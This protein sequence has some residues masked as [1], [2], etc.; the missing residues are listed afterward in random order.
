[1]KKY[2]LKTFWCSMN[3]ADSEKINMVL[4]QL[5]IKLSKKEIDADIIIFNTCSV[6]NKWEDRVLWYI[7]NIIK[8]NYKK[9]TSLKKVIWVTWCM[10]KK[11][12]LNKSY[13][14][15]ESKRKTAKKIEYIDSKD[16]IFNNDDK[17]FPK[18]KLL[19]FTFRIEELKY[20]PFILSNIYSDL[21]IN[22]YQID[23]YLKLKQL[24]DNPVSA[25]IIIQTWCDNYCSFCIVPYTRWREISRN[26]EEIVDEAK[27]AINLWAKEIILIGQN[28]N[29]YWKNKNQLNWDKI[30]NKWIDNS[31]WSLFRV[32]LNKLN[33][34]KWLDRIRFTSSNPHD[35]TD[36]ILRSH[37][38]LEKIC[39]YLHFALQ[40][41][42]ND[43]LKKM[44]RKHTYEDFK[45]QVEYLRG[46]DPLFSISTD[47]IVWFPWET[48]EMFNETIKAFEELQF[49]FAYIAR[50]SERKWT[51]ASKY[52]MDNVGDNIKSE[53]WHIL[54]NLLLKII[55]NRNKLMLWREELIL[56]QWNKDWY[57][58]WRTRNFKEVFFKWNNSIQIW[59]YVKVKI[60]EVNRY[61]LKG[62]L[63][64][65]TPL[66]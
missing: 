65:L 55:Q 4:N 59:D 48:D 7:N 40:S 28:V 44:N 17:L 63:F 56:V 54:N 27:N 42:S 30:N 9:D 16:F 31:K 23:D 36:D 43:L 33:D 11:T 24:R 46:K 52:L 66:L 6:R 21:L 29:S 12:W 57:Y 15:L 47:I 61:V 41:W 60:N 22:D 20:L 25:S 2:F 18:I 58:H 51:N 5:W 1:M 39:N 53:R 34:L 37:F 38:E 26:I 19:D 64:M 32:L 45:K 35:M 8:S 3:Y 50:Y 14:T 10:V 49:D 13:F 62:E